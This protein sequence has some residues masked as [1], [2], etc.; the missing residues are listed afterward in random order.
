[1][2]MYKGFL[3][4]LAAVL[5]AGCGGSAVDETKPLAQV[6]YEASKM[7]PVKL[8]EMVGL[9]EAAITEKTASME[10]ITAELKDLSI[11]D[12]MGEKAKT[13]KA[14]VDTLTVSLKTL[15]DHLA[16]YAKELD[17]K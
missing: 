17:A 13:L 14:E 5:I 3:V 9:Y 10:S 11:S 4:L 2:K 16:V 8:Q 1:M 6:E 15:K 7:K 12:L